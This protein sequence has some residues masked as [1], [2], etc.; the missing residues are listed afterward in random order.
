[1]R[2]ILAILLC[3]L[4]LSLWSRPAS[5]AWNLDLSA[6]SSGFVLRQL[7]PAEETDW[8]YQA[9]GLVLHGAYLGPRSGWQISADYLYAP[10]DP[11]GGA[12]LLVSEQATLKYP[13]RK[14]VGDAGIS[15]Y[16]WLLNW[17]RDRVEKDGARVISAE[18]VLIGLEAYNLLTESG[19]FGAG[20]GLGWRELTGVGYTAGGPAASVWLDFSAGLSKHAELYFSTATLWS[21]PRGGGYTILEKDTLTSLGLGIKF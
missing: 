21:Q 15:V 12:L 6:A 5:A 7:G 3:C 2:R 9:Y 19:S 10:K 20:A 8:I 11:G 17:R 16:Y 4:G 1:M 18:T 14:D 13:R